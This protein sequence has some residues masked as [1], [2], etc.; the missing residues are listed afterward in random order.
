M[1]VDLTDGGPE[2]MVRLLTFTQVEV[3][4]PGKVLSGRACSNFYFSS[5]TLRSAMTSSCELIRQ[6]LELLVGQGW[7]LGPWAV[8]F[9]ATSVSPVED[10]CVEHLEIKLFC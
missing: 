3:R 8:L 2:A 10:D 9:A 1:G 7:G 5:I 4:S 6:L